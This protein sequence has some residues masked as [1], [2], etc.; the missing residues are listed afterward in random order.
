MSI[1]PLWQQDSNFEL[2]NN[3]QKQKLETP[4]LR[5]LK[6]TGQLRSGNYNTGNKQAMWAE[7]C[8]A[9]DDSRI[10]YL[11]F[12]AWN[13]S[14]SMLQVE[15]YPE[16]WQPVAAWANKPSASIGE[17]WHSWGHWECKDK[18]QATSH[19]LAWC[20]FSRLSSLRSTSVSQRW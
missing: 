15:V 12:I 5:T 16:L 3:L 11:H 17:P 6:M 10:L 18:H 14:S 13:C 1:I 2:W 7:R 20:L 8:Y 9:W 19:F 4:V